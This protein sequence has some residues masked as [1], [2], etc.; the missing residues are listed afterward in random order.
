MLDILCISGTIFIKKKLNFNLITGYNVYIIYQFTEMADN[1]IGASFEAYYD[2]TDHKSLFKKIENESRS[3]YQPPLLSV[4]FIRSKSRDWSNVDKNTKLAKEIKNMLSNFIDT[5]EKNIKNDFIINQ[6]ENNN[7]IADYCVESLIV[8]TELKE[9]GLQVNKCP[10]N[11][12][13][14]YIKLYY[15]IELE[16]DFNFDKCVNT[17]DEITIKNK[18]ILKNI[19]ATDENIELF[20][21]AMKVTGEVF[22]TIHD[23]KKSHIKL[24]E[25]PNINNFMEIID[26][27]ISVLVIISKFLISSHLFNESLGDK[28]LELEGDIGETCMFTAEYDIKLGTSKNPY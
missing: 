28:R 1:I 19:G 12:L 22:S 6:L 11:K 9:R 10:V 17:I 4:Q 26:N 5:H 23:F 21:E 8:L 16:S 15:N 18:N 27:L 14:F 20:T 2:L 7:K 13:N 3:L 25:N 24:S